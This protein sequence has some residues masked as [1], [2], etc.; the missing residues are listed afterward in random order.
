MLL[1]LFVSTHKIS[2]PALLIMLTARR[3]KGWESVT[4]VSSRVFA[5]LFFASRV[6]FF[7]YAWLR[8]VYVWI[9]NPTAFSSNGAETTPRWV[10]I[11][12]HILFGL[13]WALQLFWA[14]EISKKCL[15]VGKATHKKH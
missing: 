3:V 1:R 14:V 10:Y 11:A 13:G 8:S 5:V 7:G 4:I 6:F 12:I 15:R 2:T 9:E